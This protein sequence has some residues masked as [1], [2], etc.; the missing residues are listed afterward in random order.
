MGYH[1]L[2]V[3]TDA[4]TV[5]GEAF[6]WLTFILYLAPHTISKA[7]GGANTCPFASKG[8]SAACLYTAG[9]G[10]FTN[11]QES[12]IRK[13]V[14]FFKDRQGFLDRLAKDVEKA[15]KYSE[16]KEMKCCFRLNG[17]SD[18]N[19]GSIFIPKFPELQF[20]DYTKSIA[21]VMEN[22]LPN[23]HLT[24]SRSESNY[25]HVLTCLAN[26]KNVAVVFSKPEFPE[27]WNGVK[28]VNGDLNDLRFLDEPGSVVGLKAKG[29]AKKDASGFVVRV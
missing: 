2:S 12:R 5:K 15:V 20:Y 10:K 29:D 14:E 8:C 28:V 24:F 23:Y 27:R 25:D 1:Y 13:T 19:W 22:D 6:G 3:G 16:K 7:F 21:R 18:I 9:M 17:T 11:V 26:E 4:K